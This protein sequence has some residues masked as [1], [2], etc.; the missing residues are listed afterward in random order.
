MSFGFL[1]IMAIISFASFYFMYRYFKKD[2]AYILAIGGAVAANIFNIGAYAINGEYFVFGIDSVVYTLFIFCIAVIYYDYD[3]KTALNLTW[4]TIA[5]IIFAGLISF[6]A[7]WATNGFG[8]SITWSLISFIVSSFATCLA[9]LGMIYAIE[10]AKIK[11]IL[12]SM[13]LMI[14]IGSLI[15]S[16]IYFGV[17]A[18][19]QGGDLGENFVK[20]LI[21]S[22][23]G[24][25]VSIVF[26]LFTYYLVQ[27]SLIKSYKE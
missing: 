26:S 25:F 9:V 3:K 11:N 6:V 8:S 17:M 2:G 22:Y 24:K 5:S 20:S 13:G 16:F 19:L 10:K 4:T 14:I 7:N 15:N 1:I 12:L 23:L 21:G 18:I 27:K